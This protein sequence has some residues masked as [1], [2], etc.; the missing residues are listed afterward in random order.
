MIDFLRYLDSKFHVDETALHRP[1]FEAMLQQL[2]VQGD[3]LE[4]G[5]GSGA[6]LRR[7]STADRLS[8][9]N[10]TICDQNPVLV[11]AVGKR[12]PGVDCR[13]G[14]LFMLDFGGRQYDMVIAQAVLDVIDMEQG[15]SLFSRILRSGG[16][17]YAPITFDGITE[18]TAPSDET[19]VDSGLDSRIIEEYHLSM[20]ERMVNGRPSGSRFAG[21]RLAHLAS[22]YGFSLISQGVSTWQVQPED[23]NYAN[24]DAYFLEAILAMLEDSVGNR[25]VKGR[26]RLTRMELDTWLYQRHSQLKA[27]RLGFTARHLDLLLVLNTSS[28]PI[29]AQTCTDRDEG[30]LTA[31]R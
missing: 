13:C 22:R 9:L 2:P 7:L 17:L 1:S 23:G 26:T 11:S 27:G 3:I 12:F 31:H 5:G 18:F 30:T 21:R 15:L 25:I 4:V 6:M 19:G 29:H 28:N 10:Y 20:D 24:D 8:Q 16:C 14:D